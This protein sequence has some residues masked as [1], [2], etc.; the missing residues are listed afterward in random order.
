[1]RNLQADLRSGCYCLFQMKSATDSIRKL[2]PWRHA[3][4]GFRERIVANDLVRRKSVPPIQ[5]RKNGRQRQEIR[6]LLPRQL[7]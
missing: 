7:P 5:L 6:K 4:R 2:P 1:M 3:L